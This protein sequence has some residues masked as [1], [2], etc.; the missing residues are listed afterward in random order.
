MQIYEG[1]K[2]MVSDHISSIENNRINN[3]DEMSVTQT[4]NLPMNMVDA[5]GLSMQEKNLLVKQKQ[6]ID[7]AGHY[8]SNMVKKKDQISI[9]QP[10]DEMQHYQNASA[11]I[12][13]T[14]GDT[15]Q[16]DQFNGTNTGVQNTINHAH[17]SEFVLI[18]NNQN[19]PVI[20]SH[21]LSDDYAI[22]PGTGTVVGG[23]NT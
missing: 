9:N 21:L 1:S 19:H 20:P 12:G 8:M 15:Q 11:S 7:G 13:H 6:S 22:Q 18:N 10:F 4:Q 3:T 17:S 14:L 2:L 23:S 5:E 16:P